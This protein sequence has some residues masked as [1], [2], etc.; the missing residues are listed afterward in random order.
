MAV[1]QEY[2]DPWV[3]GGL[4]LLL[5]LSLG[6]IQ[7]YRSSPQSLAEART[8]SLVA[9]RPDAFTPNLQRAEERLQAAAAAR[10]V[11]SD[12][13]ADVAYAMAAEHA[14]RARSA[15][16]DEAAISAATEFWAEAML[17]RAQLLQE[18]GTGR[19]LRRDDNAILRDALALAEQVLAVPTSPETRERAEEVQAAITRQ[20]RF[21]PLQWLP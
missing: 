17:Q 6:A 14:W 7:L 2:R 10:E 18:A 4:G 5:V 13:A 21:G 8:R 1:S 12:S 3:L 15:A 16:P 19:G 20:L 11:G 9:A